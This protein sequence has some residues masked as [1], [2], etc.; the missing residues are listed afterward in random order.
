[1]TDA[2]TAV[3]RGWRF[4]GSEVDAARKRAGIVV[5]GASVAGLA[6]ERSGGR[7]TRRETLVLLESRWL[8]GYDR[9][10]RFDKW[11]ILSYT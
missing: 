3:Q 8:S 1:M 2:A 10:L 11:E 7:E 9:G 5:A 6:V 4:V